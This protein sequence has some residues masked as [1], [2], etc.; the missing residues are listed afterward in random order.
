MYNVVTFYASF[1]VLVMHFCK[2]QLVQFLAILPSTTNYY[3]FVRVWIYSVSTTTM[4]Q[5]Q[6]K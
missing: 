4:L 6:A 5:F 2:S 1:T 3:V